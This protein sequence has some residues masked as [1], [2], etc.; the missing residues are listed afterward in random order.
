MA[1]I[2][3]KRWSP[4]AFDPNTPIDMDILAVIFEAARWAPSSS[5]EQ[6]WRYIIGQN[7]DK[8]HQ[9]ILAT[10]NE[11]NQVWAQNAPVLFIACAKLTRNDRPSRTALHDL[12]L[13]SQI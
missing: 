6:P 10:L 2:F 4:R 12:G 3:S 5:N 11:N 8:S 7:F 13:S 9:D 1:Q